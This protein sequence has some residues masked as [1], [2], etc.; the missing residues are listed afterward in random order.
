VDAAV[1]VLNADLGPLHRVSIR[2]AVRMLF[3]EVAVVHEAEPDRQ[4]GVWPMPKVVRLVTYVVTK[5]RYSSGPA[6]SRP[7]VLDRDG[8]RCTYCHGPATTIN[9]VLRVRPPTTGAA[10]QCQNRTPRLTV[11]LIDRWAHR[12]RGAGLDQIA[13]ASSPKAVTTRSRWIASVP[14]S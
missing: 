7:G 8:R 12:G 9:H 5:W 2:H 3:R 4:L 1:L 6:W 14:S 11:A 13:W 10:P